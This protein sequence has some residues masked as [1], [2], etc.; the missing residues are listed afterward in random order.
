MLVQP[1]GHHCTSGI[2]FY[3]KDNVM[4]ICSGHIVFSVPVTNKIQEELN[5]AEI[6]LF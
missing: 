1:D 5:Q 3:V 4:D 2:G 6:S